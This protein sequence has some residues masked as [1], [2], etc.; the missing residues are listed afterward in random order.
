VIVIHG[1]S[2]LFEGESLGAGYPQQ[3]NGKNNIYE[4]IYIAEQH[5]YIVCDP[6][7]TIQ[8]RLVSPFV[9]DPI[10]EKDNKSDANE[11]N[12]V[13]IQLPVIMGDH[14]IDLVD[15]EQYD[16]KTI[17]YRKIRRING[18]L[19]QHEVLRDPDQRDE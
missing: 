16:Q 12:G 5:Y 2:L 11:K 13:A 1:L 9:N 4:G 15:A 8:A 6:G 18:N 3:R 14:E 17:E 10:D 19:P 7:G